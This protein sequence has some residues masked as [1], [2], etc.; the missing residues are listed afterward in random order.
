MGKEAIAREYFEAW[1]NRDFG[2]IEA[3]VADD[4][5]VID[6]DGTV[7]RGPAGARKFAEL[8][9]AAFPDGKLEITS[10]ASAGD[11]VIIEAIGRGTH[12]GPFGDIPATHRYAELPYCD[13][14]T[15]RGDKIARDRQYGDM[16][17]LLTQLGLMPEPAHA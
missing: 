13:I 17:T 12:D 3:L 4:A 10:I 1:N 8:Y 2:R 7:E 15:F 5:E 9:A 6:F 14:L 11:T 16:A